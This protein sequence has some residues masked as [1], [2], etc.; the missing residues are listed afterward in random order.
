[1]FV[2]GLLQ[3]VEDRRRMEAGE[4][5]SVGGLYAK[6]APKEGGMHDKATGLAKEIMKAEEF[7]L[8]SAFPLI[9][10][11]YIILFQSSFLF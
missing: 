6:W 1:M 9:P 4:A 2:S 8:F 3:E 11:F 7:I 5:R 10:I